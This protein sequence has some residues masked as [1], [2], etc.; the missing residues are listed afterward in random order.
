[1]VALKQNRLLV[2]AIVLCAAA[3]VVVFAYSTVNPV[4]DDSGNSV[5]PALYQTGGDMQNY[6]L[7]AYKLFERPIEKLF[8][9]YDKT[10]AGELVDGGTI[11]SFAPLFPTL[12]YVLDYRENNTWPTAAFF[13]ACSVILAAIWLY[14]LQANGVTGLWLL[15]F[16]VIPLPIWYTISV[17]SDMPFAL[18]FALFFMTYFREKWSA[19]VVVIW[20]GL[21]ILILLARPNGLAVLLF[22]LADFVVRGLRGER[23]VVALVVVALLV[24]AGIPSVYYYYPQFLAFVRVSA[25]ATF[26]SVPADAYVA[27]LFPE[28]P[29]VFDRIVSILLLIAAKLLYFVGLRPSYSDQSLVI[30]ALRAA[31]GLILLPGLIVALVQAGWRMRML[32]LIFCFPILIGASQE[33][34]ILPIQPILYLFGVVALQRV[35]DRSTGRW[36]A[37]R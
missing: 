24:G 16:S 21:L 10:Y 20:V 32:L 3:R 4:F 7:T 11:V 37:E 26:F 13:L 23:R 8:R 30:V 6:G 27:G 17:T 29:G 14:W 19:G 33:R 22:V 25:G 12:I 15:A 2:Y 18:L 1:M 35:L 36:R 31:P 5:S 34:Y 28:W 9:D